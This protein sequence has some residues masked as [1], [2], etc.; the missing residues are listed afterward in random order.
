MYKCKPL[1]AVTTLVCLSIVVAGCEST[2]VSRS[3]KNVPISIS[4]AKVI[5]AEVVDLQ[6]D[7]GRNA[8][9][10]AVVGGVI[11]LATGQNF[12]GA[13]AGAGLGALGVGVSTRAAEGSQ[14]AMAYIVRGG[15]GR[16]TKVVTEDKHLIVG[17]CVA[18]ETGRTANLRRVS[19][20]MC[21]PRMQHPVE[22][23]LRSMHMEEAQECDAA[24]QELLSAQSDADIDAAVKRVRVLCKH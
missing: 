23:E 13:A 5:S 20:E 11:G 7:V 4:Y 8:T 18:V 2:G 3:D 15:D 17:D 12:A 16:E 22:S 9:I 6:S 10:G 1:S 14:E 19:D 21:G 24:K